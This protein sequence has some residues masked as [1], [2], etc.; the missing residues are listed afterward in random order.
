MA[1]V[2]T[3]ERQIGTLEGFNVILRHRDGRDVRSDRTG[4]PGY[5]FLNRAKGKMTVAQWKEVRFYP[6]FSGWDVDVLDA[7]DRSC[8]GNTLLSSVRETYEE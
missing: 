5:A 6:G 8:Q 7:D 4:L 1:S 3:V 2:R